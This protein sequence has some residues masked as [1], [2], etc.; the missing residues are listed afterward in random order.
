MDDS[1]ALRERTFRADCGTAPL[2]MICYCRRQQAKSTLPPSALP[3]SAGR[4][5]GVTPQ[6]HPQATLSVNISTG[7]Y[8]LYPA[9]QQSSVWFWNS[10]VYPSNPYQYSVTCMWISGPYLT[11]GNRCLWKRIPNVTAYKHVLLLQQAWGLQEPLESADINGSLSLGR[12]NSDRVCLCCYR[13]GYH[14]L[15][16]PGIS[17]KVHNSSVLLSPDLQ[18]AVRASLHSPCHWRSQRE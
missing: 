3:S 10:H 18:P 8:F 14:W 1:E 2:R 13:C 16:V 6:S 4:Q 9:E 17:I 7:A 12:H 11:Q 5:P 15:L